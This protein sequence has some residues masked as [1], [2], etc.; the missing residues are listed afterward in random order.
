LNYTVAQVGTSAKSS[1]LDSSPLSTKGANGISSFISRLGPVVPFGQKQRFCL[2]LVS[3]VVG[4]LCCKLFPLHALNSDLML[5]FT[6]ASA[7]TVACNDY[8]PTGGTSFAE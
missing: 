5:H 2:P 1:A 7:N 6:L 8:I 4:S 3:G